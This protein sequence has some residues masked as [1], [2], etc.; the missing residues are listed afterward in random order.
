MTV[1]AIGGSGTVGQ[2]LNGTYGVLT[3]NSDG[4]IYVANG[5]EDA[6]AADA[7]VT[8][9]FTYT[10]SDGA[11]TTATAD[12]VITVTGYPQAVADTGSNRMPL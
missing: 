12:L 9:T 7:T 6:L 5:R 1:S 4:V 3:L 11:G 8:D 10:V 2:A